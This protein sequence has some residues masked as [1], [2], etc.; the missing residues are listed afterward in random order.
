MNNWNI[1]PLILGKGPRDKSFFTYLKD[2]GVEIEIG[3]LAWLVFNED[4]KIIVDTGPSLPSKTAK[5]HKPF[6][7]TSEQTLEAQLKRFNTSFDEIKIVI[8]S[9]LH[10]DHCYGNSLFKKARFYV[11]KREVE[12][13]RDPLP[14]S[15]QMY[16]ARQEGIVP[17][18]EGID[19]EF[20]EGDV[21]L[22]PGIRVMLTPGHTPGIQAVCVQ[23][24][25][26]M[27]I[28]AGDT[29]P[30]FENLNVPDNDPFIPSGNFVELK[31]YFTSLDRIKAL[32]GT[33]LPGHDPK[34]MEKSEYP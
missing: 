29:I 15:A 16:E 17:P 10:W 23:T 8:N 4:Q 20:L 9:H 21:D 34:V 30:L 24:R 7:Q 28:I 2:P 3:M 5:F 32:G 11:Q 18:F 25:R 13:A 1:A 6:T 27:Y 19:F 14:T 22:I 26:G 33:I 31:E 12:Y